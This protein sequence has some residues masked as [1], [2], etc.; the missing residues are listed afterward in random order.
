MSRQLLRGRYNRNPRMEAA[1]SGI[2][3]MEPARDWEA[4]PTDIQEH[5]ELLFAAWPSMHF[6]SSYLS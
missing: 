6:Q 2:D 1:R 5:D 3:W 4:R